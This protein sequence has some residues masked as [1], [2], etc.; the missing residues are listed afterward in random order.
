MPIREIGSIEWLGRNRCRPPM[1]KCFALLVAFISCADAS[2]LLAPMSHVCGIK[3][4]I[5]TYDAGLVHDGGGIAAAPDDDS[6]QIGGGGPARN[7]LP[8]DGELP[9]L[10]ADDSDPEPEEL[11]HP[12]DRK[13]CFGFAGRHQPRQ[14]AVS[15]AASV[16]SFCTFKRLRN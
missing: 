4:L 12:G 6:K 5:Q 11:Q 3:P 7:E 13:V 1:V 9:V 16:T 15:S 14:G 8:Q 10:F 2:F